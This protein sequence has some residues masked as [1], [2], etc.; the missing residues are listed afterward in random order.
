MATEAAVI[1]ALN[2]LGTIFPNREV[3][4]ALILVYIEALDDISDAALLVACG[5]AMKQARFFPVPAEIRG[6]AEPVMREERRELRE[7]RLAAMPKPPPALPM[8]PEKRKQLSDCIHALA[9]KMGI[10]RQV[11]VAPTEQKRYQP[12][13]EPRSPEECIAELKRTGELS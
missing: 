9:R 5:A 6:F 1:A 3:T 8:P 13:R 7:A 12:T 4:D 10:G 11:R 2:K